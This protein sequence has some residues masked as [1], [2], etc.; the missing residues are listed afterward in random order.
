M[1]LFE[2]HCLSLIIEHQTYSIYFQFSVVSNKT[3]A[4]PSQLDTV[5][6]QDHGR[7]EEPNPTSYPLISTFILWHQYVHTHVRTH[8]HMH[9]LNN[10]LFKTLKKRLLENLN[11]IYGSV[12]QN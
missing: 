8:M 2:K 10:V 7:R 6:S 1:I 11:C 3:E 5:A 9:T 12:G 4:S